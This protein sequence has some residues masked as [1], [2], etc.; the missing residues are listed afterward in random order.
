MNPPFEVIL[1]VRGNRLAC[2][3]GK[4]WM[5]PGQKSFPKAIGETLGLVKPVEDEPSEGFG[6]NGGVEI[7]KRHELSAGGKNA[8]G[9]K[10]VEMWVEIGERSE[11]LQAGHEAGNRVGA[12]E[13]SLEADP[14]RLVGAAREEA[15]ETPVALEE[16]SERF[17]NC[18]HKMPMADRCQDLLPKFLGEERRA[19]GLA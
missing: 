2:E 13:D 4:T 1:V 19:F 10:S 15:E 18:E 17:G 6:E 16:S 12:A 14:D 7:R 9:H 11:R 8:I 3:D 5:N